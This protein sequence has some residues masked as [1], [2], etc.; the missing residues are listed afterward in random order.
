MSKGLV[1]VTGAT[2]FVGTEVS[3]QL[4]DA[5]YSVR[6]TSRS[7]GKIKDWEEFN[8]EYKSKMTC[9]LFLRGLFLSSSF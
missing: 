8:P 4:I 9:T 3:R 1:L 6:G 2:G 7:Q 5:G